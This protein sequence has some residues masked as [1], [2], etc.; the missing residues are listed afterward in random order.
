MIELAATVK[1]LVGSRS[2]LIHKALPTDD[3]RQRQP[4]ISLAREAL[5]WQPRVTPQEGLKPTV[6]YFEQ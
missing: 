5:G 3:P 4:E 2:Q 1:A 6:A